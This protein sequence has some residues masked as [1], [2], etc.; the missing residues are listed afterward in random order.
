MEPT[1]LPPLRVPVYVQ[2]KRDL[3]YDVERA[4][5]DPTYDPGYQPP[6]RMGGPQGIRRSQWGNPITYVVDAG[7]A[8]KQKALEAKAA[9][10]DVEAGVYAAGYMAV[11]VA[12]GGLRTLA[13][14]G[15]VLK[16]PIGTLADIGYVATHLRPT[17][18]AV[19]M[20]LAGD[21][22]RVVGQ[23][24]GGI[25]VGAIASDVIAT[26]RG[27]K[28]VKTVET[29]TFRRSRRVGQSYAKKTAFEPEKV[30]VHTDDFLGSHQVQTGGA[31]PKSGRTGLG[32]PH[33][34]QTGEGL[35]QMVPR[36]GGVEQTV[37]K[38]TTRVSTMPR[39]V[40][41]R[42]LSH[43]S[44]LRFTSIP[45]TSS[46]VG[47]LAGGALGTFTPVKPSPPLQ[48]PRRVQD[49]IQGQGMRAKLMTE[50]ALVHGPVSRSKITPALVL[51]GYTPM[52]QKIVPISRTRITPVLIAPEYTQK[53]TPITVQTQNVRQAVIPVTRTV[54]KT[55]KTPRAPPAPYIPHMRHI[56]LTAPAPSRRRRRKKKM[57][58]VPRSL[59]I[60]GQFREYPVKT[61]EMVLRS[62]RI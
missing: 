15:Q 29:K 24:G 9:G 13:V 30:V 47:P 7:Q 41:L 46:I 61:P 57:G 10:R 21:P 23:V 50:Q 37:Y 35:T 25:L 45:R 56:S 53:L 44:R 17:I 18:A 22:V 40:S 58:G 43:A 31:W 4:R 5:R 20:S 14:P 26:A 2:V 34:V 54:S 6:R 12:E 39:S 3:G 11:S 55:Q 19:G 48:R 52:P 42:G 36:S 33:Y 62:L 59:Q 51:P 27:P 32:K 38:L 49:Q 1:V 28:T 60:W 16:D 8:A